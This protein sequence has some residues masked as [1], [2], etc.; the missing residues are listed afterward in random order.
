MSKIGRDLKNIFV[1]RFVVS[2]NNFSA[3]N[4]SNVSVA[5]NLYIK[6]KR[7]GIAYRKDRKTKDAFNKKIQ[8]KKTYCD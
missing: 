1:E 5:R 2:V 6:G 7:N 3:R 8:A 4:G